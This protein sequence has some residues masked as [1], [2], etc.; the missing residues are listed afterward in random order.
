VPIGVTV[1]GEV[2]FPF[3]CKDFM[4]GARGGQTSTSAEINPGQTA[5]KEQP[6]TELIET[7]F[8]LGE[9][10]PLPQPR[11]RRLRKLISFAG[12]DAVAHP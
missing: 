8:K 4:R 12:V 5:D 6:H 2:V 1:G 9:P 3:L 7:V 10:I 11:P